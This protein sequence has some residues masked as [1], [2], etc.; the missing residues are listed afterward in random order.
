MTWAKFDDATVGHPKVRKAGRDGRALWYA[1]VIESS[2]KNT[3]GIIEPLVASDVAHL[4]EVDLAAGVAACIEAG[5][6]HDHR[7]IRK[8][9]RCR[10]R[11]K[12]SSGAALP[13]GWWYL[14]DFLDYQ[15]PR[16]T[17]ARDRF[18]EQRRR[19]L[20]RGEGLKIREAVM[21]RD[22]DRCRYC[23]VTV[24]WGDR[25]T[26]PIG[27]QI[28]HVDPMGPNSMANCV[29]SCRDCNRLK[30]DRTAAEVGLTLLPEP[31]WTSPGRSPGLVPGVARELSPPSGRDGPGP[32]GSERSGPPVVGLDQLRSLRVAEASR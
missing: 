3:D 26:S 24:R 13:A 19:A 10:D 32:D 18:I 27:G 20:Y 30:S 28:D 11:C 7:T 8:C 1:L 31:P 9:E 16:V 4:A 5:L 15:P 6:L 2:S 14:H 21:A 25:T 22:Q 23:D 12:G 17:V 29:V